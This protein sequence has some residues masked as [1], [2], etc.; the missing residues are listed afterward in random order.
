MSGGWRDTSDEEVEIEQLRHAISR[1]KQRL[2]EVTTD[3]DEWREQHEN[4]VSVRSTDLAAVA[5]A[6]GDIA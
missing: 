4:L 3:R 5:K 1:L 6:R 2:R